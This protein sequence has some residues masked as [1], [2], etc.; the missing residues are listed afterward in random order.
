MFGGFVVFVV[1]L[2]LSRDFLCELL[3]AD[4]ISVS[5]FFQ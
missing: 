1:Y 2:L 5:G 4:L 3:R